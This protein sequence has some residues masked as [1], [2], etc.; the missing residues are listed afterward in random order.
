MIVELV[1]GDAK[2]RIARVELLTN[3]GVLE[4]RSSACARRSAFAY[5][6]GKPN[7]AS[8]DSATMSRGRRLLCTN[9]LAPGVVSCPLSGGELLQKT[10]LTNYLDKA[11]S[12][13]VAAAERL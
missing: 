1:G 3:R 7:G 9:E 13:L 5:S 6:H 11:L 10:I 12:P 4:M 2:C 8:W